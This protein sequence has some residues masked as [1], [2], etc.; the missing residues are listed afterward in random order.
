LKR[1]GELTG[2]SGRVTAPSQS[3]IRGGEN[4]PK[5]G[6]IDYVIE[7]IELSVDGLRQAEESLQ[8]LE[9]QCN[10]PVERVRIRAD[11]NELEAMQDRQR[12]YIRKALGGY[13]QTLDGWALETLK[14]EPSYAQLKG[15][16]ELVS[17]PTQPRERCGARL[18]TRSRKAA[19]AT[20]PA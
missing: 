15:D 14:S 6:E 11:W 13:R 5:V 8:G 7:Q 12:R 18:G 9:M 1:H 10:D 19:P 16:L 4:V 20:T 17:P 2:V 3:S